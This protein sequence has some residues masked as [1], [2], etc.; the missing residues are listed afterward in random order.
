MNLGSGSG[1]DVVRSGKPCKLHLYSVG[2]L[3]NRYEDVKIINGIYRKQI[4]L[5]QI[6]LVFQIIK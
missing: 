1:R 3:E 2:K 6:K 5:C 4:G